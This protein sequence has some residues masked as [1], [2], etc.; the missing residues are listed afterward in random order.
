VKL[1]EPGRIGALDVKN[2]IVLAAMGIRGIVDEDGNWGERTRAFYVARAAGGAGVITTEMMFVKKD[3]EYAAKDSFDILDNRHQASLQMLSDAIHGHG[4]KL[5][6]Q[7]TAGF[8][9]V[10]P[11]FIYPKWWQ[12]DPLDTSLTPI[13]ASVNENHYLPKNPH[14]NTRPLT[15][16]EAAAHAQAFGT[17]ARRVRE[18]GAD[19]V[20]M[21][22]HEGYLLDQFMTGLW[23]RREDRYGGSAEK[24]L[25][26]AREAIAAIQAEA[27][28]D[29]PIIYR[30]GLTHYMEGG[31][32]IEE[33]LWIAQEL[34]KMGVAALHIDAGCYET[35]WWPHPP[36]YQVPGCMVNLAAQV[37][38]V[39]DVPVIAV[40]RLQYPELAEKVLAESQADFIALGRGLLAD[41]DWVNKVEAGKTSEIIPCIGCHEG[42]LEEMTNGRPTSCALNP[43]TGHEIEWPLLPVK[44]K[45]T[46]LVV[47]GGPAGLEAARAGVKRGLEVTLWEATGRLGGNLWPAA[48]PD[49]K[50]DIALYLDYLTQMELRM[51]VDVVF[52][53]RATA[54]DVKAFGADHVILAT[55]AQMEPAPFAGTA[56]IEVV[57]AIE[58]LCGAEPKG[59]RILVM[60]GGLIGCETALYLSRQGKQVTLTTRREAAKLGGDIADRSNRKVLLQM[61]D[62][63]G[64]T[65]LAETLPVRLE[66]AS[67]VVEREAAQENIPIDALVFAGRL[68]PQTQIAE[69]LGENAALVSRVGDCV[70]PD[71]IKAAVWAS[72]NTVRQMEA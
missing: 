53:K 4:A 38:Q 72:F 41:P 21:H 68:M 55:G 2:R 45:E 9:R 20:E 58:T 71:T 27:G 61:I 15:T 29:F 35:H 31:R 33:G 64:I 19:C 23:N 11:P 12:S 13:S 30:F 34:E 44:K 59:T 52:N 14:F 51:P 25:T 60:G 5:S 17:A 63:A 37:R 70:K 39:V 24:R 32:E 3:L 57:T 49:F 65:V 36:Q 66:E 67:V 62:E 28:A 10:V 47:G 42:C 1:L 16:D 46:L 22:G 18:A 48:K 56:A 43:T 8:G 26:F 6:V 7:L 40:G 69:L 54:A 50:H